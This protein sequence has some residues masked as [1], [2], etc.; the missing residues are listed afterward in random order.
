M[1]LRRSKDTFARMHGD[2]SF[3]LEK[4][5][6]FLKDRRKEERVS[7]PL[8]KWKEEKAGSTWNKFEECG[9]HEHELLRS[10]AGTQ[11]VDNPAAASL[12][13]HLHGC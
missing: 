8:D 11:L 5:Q 13:P 10:A 9:V 1:S 7:V 12:V 2:G 4:E 6:C 3:G